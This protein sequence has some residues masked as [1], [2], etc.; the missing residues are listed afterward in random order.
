MMMMLLA[1]CSN[2]TGTETQSPAGTPALSAPANDPC[3]LLTDV[4]VRKIFPNAAR[5][6]LDRRLESSGIVSCVWDHPGGRFIAQWFTG[7]VAPV[8]SEIRSRASGS[9]DPTKR[10]ARDNVRY[11]TLTG[12]GDRAM[13]VVERADD[14]KG[15]LS[16]MALLVV[17]RGARQ[18][19]FMSTQLAERDRD[20]ALAALETLGRSAASR[21]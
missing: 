17:R 6:S 21:L 7:E 16:D 1:G 19:V 9:V 20:A 11:E 3:G 18:V 5:G 10:G 15:I 12:V 4:E 14:Q 8:E 2:A 13:A